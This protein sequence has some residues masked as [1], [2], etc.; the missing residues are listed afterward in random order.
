MKCRFGLA[1]ILILGIAV[2]LGM[3]GEVIELSPDVKAVQLTRYVWLYTTS[4]ELPGDQGSISG[5][6][7]VVVNGSSAMLIDMPWSDEHTGIVAEWVGEKFGAKIECVVP[8]HSHQDCAGGLGAANGLGAE[9]WALHKTTVKLYDMGTVI[10]KKSF[11]E[12]R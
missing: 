12:K 5:N 4:A 3:G 6:G 1:F 7:L 9:S 8:T 2:A 10:P 11:T